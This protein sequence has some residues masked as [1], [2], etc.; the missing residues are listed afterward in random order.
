MILVSVL[1]FSFHFFTSMASVSQNMN[2]YLI[3]TVQ[4]AFLHPQ[5][6]KQWPN[7]LLLFV[8][9]FLALQVLLIGYPL[10]SRYFWIA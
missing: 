7:F 4:W 2:R 6:L 8:K 1:A 10:L 3:F 9:L 5:R